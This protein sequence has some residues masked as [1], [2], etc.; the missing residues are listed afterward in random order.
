MEKHSCASPHQCGSWNIVALSQSQRNCPDTCLSVVSALSIKHHPTL[1]NRSTQWDSILPNNQWEGWET[2]SPNACGR[3]VLD[4]TPRLPEEWLLT[5]P[6]P[7]MR[8][9]NL[10]KFEE[11]YLP[12]YFSL[13]ANNHLT[14]DTPILSP[15]YPSGWPMFLH[16]LSLCCHHLLLQGVQ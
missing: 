15:K 4:D 2:F 8:S 9:A 13:T 16:I 7:I 14:T 12:I 3:V 11:H 6:C 5:S 10:E 1:K